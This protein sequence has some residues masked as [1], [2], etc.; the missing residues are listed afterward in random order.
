MLIYHFVY[1]KIYPIKELIR[2]KKY[3]LPPKHIFKKTVDR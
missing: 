1:F 2:N 3:S